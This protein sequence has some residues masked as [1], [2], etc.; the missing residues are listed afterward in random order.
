MN[1]RQTELNINKYKV[2]KNKSNHIIKVNTFTY[3][4]VNL[5]DQSVQYLDKD[6]LT[7]L[8]NKKLWI[9]Q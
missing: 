2:F 3:K 6:T 5:T 8:T 1:I 4:A 7:R 9:E